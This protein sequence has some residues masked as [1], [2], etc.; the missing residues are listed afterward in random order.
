MIT[1]WKEEDKDKEEKRK[2]MIRKRAYK[3][4]EGERKITIRKGGD[5]H[6]EGDR[7]PRK[8][9]D[10]KYKEEKMRKIKIGARKGKGE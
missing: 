3:D 5:K 4:K 2:K 6:K 1:A 8:G 9:I 10:D 7:R